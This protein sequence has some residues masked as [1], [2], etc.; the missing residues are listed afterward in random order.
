MAARKISRKK[1]KQQDEFYGYSLKILNWISRKWRYALAGIAFFFAILSIIWG[2]NTYLAS[3]RNK[4]IVKFYKGLNLYEQ[5]DSDPDRLRE[6]RDIF[7]QV[8]DSYGG[9]I[10]LQGLLY[11]GNINYKEGNFQQAAEDYLMLY[12]RAGKK[13]A[14]KDLAIL[15][16]AYAYESMKEYGKAVSYLQEIIDSSESSLKDQAYLSLARCYEQ[17]NDREKA[18]SVY[19]EALEKFPQA[20]WH[21]VIEVKVQLLTNL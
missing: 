1:L 7:E 11:L 19:Q 8:K 9:D 6:A 13:Q 4:N 20:P 5:A 3:Q 2:I 15:G 16:L 17:M 14:L 10:T 21:N 18:I 12:R